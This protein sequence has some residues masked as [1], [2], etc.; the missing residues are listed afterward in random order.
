[1]GLIWGRRKR[2]KLSNQGIVM[3]PNAVKR[4]EILFI[5]S[6]QNLLLNLLV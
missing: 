4:L 5:G 3:P 6:M 1:M 2:Y